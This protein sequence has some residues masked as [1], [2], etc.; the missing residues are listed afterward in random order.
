[1]LNKENK[2]NHN[3]DEIATISIGC[4]QE[5]FIGDFPNSTS[6]SPTTVANSAVERDAGLGSHLEVSPL[7]WLDAMLNGIE[8]TNFFNFFENRV[9]E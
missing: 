2:E 5:V 1:M 4:F 9:L 3:T 6:S 7:P 8:H